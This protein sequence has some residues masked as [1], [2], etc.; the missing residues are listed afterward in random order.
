MKHIDKKRFCG[1]RKSAFSV[2]KFAEGEEKTGNGGEG[3]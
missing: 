2:R 3:E 1:C